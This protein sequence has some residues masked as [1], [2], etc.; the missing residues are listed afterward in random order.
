MATRRLLANPSLAGGYSDR[1]GLCALGDKRI[2]GR[3]LACPVC[4]SVTIDR[5]VS[6]SVRKAEVPLVSVWMTHPDGAV[7][8]YLHFVFGRHLASSSCACERA[9]TKARSQWTRVGNAPLNHGSPPSRGRGT[10]YAR[11]P[12]FCS[13]TYWPEPQ[14]NLSADQE[15]AIRS[16]PAKV[17]LSEVLADRDSNIRQGRAGRVALESDEVVWVAKRNEC[18]SQPAEAIPQCVTRRLRRAPARTSRLKGKRSPCAFLR[19]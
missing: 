10:W 17:N 16:H 9:L 7:T 5:T 19:S 11:Q 2:V 12:G 13:E 6:P 18:D 4:R 3:P 1:Q 15:G 8:Y 14:H